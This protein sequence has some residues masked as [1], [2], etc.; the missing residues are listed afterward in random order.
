MYTKPVSTEMKVSSCCM[1][2]REGKE[3]ESRHR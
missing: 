3:D 2:D 1:G